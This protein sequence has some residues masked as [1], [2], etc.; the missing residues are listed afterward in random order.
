MR[1]KGFTLVELLVVFG[2]IAILIAILLP[3]LSK[4]RSQTSK[5][6]CMTNLNQT[7]AEI[8]PAELGNWMPC[9]SREMCFRICG[10]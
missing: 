7:A 8:V 9:F 2:I 4:V 6:K 5:L 1:Q 10:V 3:A